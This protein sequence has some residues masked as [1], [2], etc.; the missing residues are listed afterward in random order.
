MFSAYLRCLRLSVLTLLAIAAGAAAAECD[1]TPNAALKAAYREGR[2]S[3]CAHNAPLLDVLHAV[4]DVSNLGLVVHTL[5]NHTISVRLDEAPLRQALDT[6]LREQS[7]VLQTNSRSDSR[8]RHSNTLWLLPARNQVYGPIADTASD[9]ALSRGQARLLSGAPIVRQE[10]AI[11]L[12]ELHDERAIAALSVALADPADHVKRAAIG[13][14]ASIGGADAA[15]ALAKGLADR[16]PRIREVSVN[17]LASFGD[18]V[19]SALVQSALFDEVAYVR[20]AAGEV[21][22]PLTP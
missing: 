14:L 1:A 9:V 3:V 5:P 20:A 8:R 11:A 16:D 2:L 15:R 17:A 7:F 21:M 12:G 22:A 18:A 4:A 19:A 6:I 13:A 10:A